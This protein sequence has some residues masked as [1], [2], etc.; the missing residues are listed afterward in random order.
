MI[1]KCFSVIHLTKPTTTVSFKMLF[2]FFYDKKSVGEY[3]HTK[4][5]QLDTPVAV[6]NAFHSGPSAAAAT[7][8]DAGGLYPTV[9]IAEGAHVMLTANIWQQV[10]LCN[11]AAGVVYQEGHSPPN[12][13]IAVLVQ[14][15][16]YTGPPFFPTTP[17]VS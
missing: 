15:P 14:F 5:A 2:A 10:G 4:L 16:H 9:L 3:N 17:N 8:D 7:P 13:P 11:G 1:G 6:V 12:L